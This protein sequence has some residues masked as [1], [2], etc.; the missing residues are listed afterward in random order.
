LDKLIAFVESFDVS[1]IVDATPVKEIKRIVVTGATGFVGRHFVADLLKCSSVSIE[2]IYC[3]VRASD[4][5]TALQ[6]LVEAMEEAGT[7]NDSHYPRLCVFKGDLQDEYLGTSSDLYEEM[8]HSVDAVYHFA[9]NLNLAATFEEMRKSNC[10]SM[11]SVLRLCLSAQR[12]HLFLASTCAIFP[13]YFCQFGNEMADKQI[14]RDA[15]PEIP[16]MKKI[17]PLA[18]GGYGW[19]KLINE[20]AAYKATQSKGLPLAVFRLPVMFTNSKTGYSVYADPMV[21]L[22][23]ASLQMRLVPGKERPFVMEDSALS[24]EMMLRISLNP[25]R[26]NTIYH[27]SSPSDAFLTEASMVDMLGFP[28]QITSYS[29]FKSQCLKLGESSPVNAYWMLLDHFAPYWINY[30]NAALEFPID[31]S[32]VAEDCHP[33]PSKANSIKVVC[34][35]L[36]WAFRQE[37]PPFDVS[38]LYAST[39]LESILAPAKKLC[40]MYNMDFG[41]VVKPF[42]IEGL[43]RIC[44]ELHSPKSML[45]EVALYLTS[46]IET[47][48]HLQRLLEMHPEIKEERIDSPLFVLGL[49]RTGTTLLHRMLEA[50]GRFEAPHIEDQVALPKAE[51]LAEP[52]LDFTRNRLD[53]LRSILEGYV[54]SADGIHDIEMSVAEEDMCA[55]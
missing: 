18:I 32:T 48:V 34:G 31:I 27:C 35:S 20:L 11:R 26:K 53:F 6:R 19:S 49:N 17:F 37:S 45:P 36:E 21:R 40:S 2:T 14:R 29:N 16:L 1:E 46:R 38:L 44:Q 10:I 30:K 33:L 7:W 5:D 54:S 3:P 13:Q 28:C 24:N 42:V 55:H 9:S 39:D 25:N 12:K 41:S 22:F 15:M 50:S 4:D 47:R 8:V 52:D 43:Q 51:Q 23:F